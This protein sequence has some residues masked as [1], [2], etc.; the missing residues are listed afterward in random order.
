MI[1]PKHLATT[2]AMLLM[3]CTVASD[4]GAADKT[5]AEFRDQFI[6]DFQ[7]TGLNTTPGD[8]MMLRILVQAQGAKRGVEVG[9]AS[10]FGAVNMGIGFERTG[11][12]LYTLEIDPKR[13]DDTRA[14][15]AKVGLEKTV[16]CITG[17]ALKTLATLEGE[18]DFLFLDAAKQQYLQYLKIMEPKLKPGSV[19]VAD[20]VIKLG[21]NMQDFLDYIE[22]SPAY[23]T[24]T[25]MAS[26]EKGDGMLI[27]FKLD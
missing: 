19:I 9:A 4:V 26:Q 8:A 24:V 7:R 22:S 5:S 11:G 20:N 12:H 14:N 21:R 10:G 16:T 25:I 2:A 17:D 23:D 27:A 1:R 6:A 18:F 3:A 13:A 15:L